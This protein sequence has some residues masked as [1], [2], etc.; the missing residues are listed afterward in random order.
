M[1]QTLQ[2]Q[3]IAMMTIKL[4]WETLL[5][6]Q[7]QRKN[8]LIISWVYINLQV[9]WLS[10]VRRELSIEIHK[11]QNTVFLNIQR[12]HRWLTNKDKIL[13]SLL[14]FIQETTSHLFYTNQLLKLSRINFFITAITRKLNTSVRLQLTISTALREE[15]SNED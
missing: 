9:I 12:Q 15:L 2:V 7:C 8:I 11:P 10:K 4:Y 1:T 3:C 6:G 5:R 13:N 14:S